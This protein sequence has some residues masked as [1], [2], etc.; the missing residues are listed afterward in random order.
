MKKFFR[1]FS[2]LG[3]LFL[4]TPQSFA[5]VPLSPQAVADVA[6][7]G[8]VHIGTHISGKAQVPGVKVDVRARRFEVIPDSV[9][10]I[11]LDEYVSGSGFVIEESG[12]IATNAH[13]VSTETLK[14]ELASES[15]LAGLFENALYLSETEMDELLKEGESGFLHDLLQFVIQNSTFELESRSVILDPHYEV[16]DFPQ[17]VAQGSPVTLVAE[18]AGFLDG[19][20]DIA[21]LKVEATPAPALLLGKSET[22]SVGSRVFLLGFPATAELA[23]TGSSEASF[24][25]GVISAI[26]VTAEGRK[27]YQTDA[28]VSQGSSGGPLL[29]EAG[30]VVGIVTFQTDALERESGDNFA[31]AQ[32]IDGVRTL[33][34]T[35]RI[36]PGESEYS[37]NFRKGFELFA[38]RRC[39]KALEYFRRG[40]KAHPLYAVTDALESYRQ[41]CKLWQEAG[42]SRDSLWASWDGVFGGQ[43]L[44]IWLLLGGSLLFG[45][46]LLLFVLW[47]LRQVRR[48]EL[49]IE[50]LEA[51]LRTDERHMFRQ[52]QLLRETR[53]ELPKTGVPLKSAKPPFGQPPKVPKL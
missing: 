29:D 10:E 35:L 12:F 24:T 14:H 33:A 44:S 36:T 30:Q 48:D 28:K 20:E 31:F 52:D 19:G 42:T 7:P 46:A 4:T 17:A 16:A 47:L 3:I 6:R 40:E 38:E 51:R 18:T 27:I 11:P 25:S 49:E 2:L 15:A 50:R 8:V 53:S 37:Q 43:R 39:Q 1:A 22:L 41:D 23:R 32:S 13:V 45:V 5:A 34:E 9:K 21:L 26:R